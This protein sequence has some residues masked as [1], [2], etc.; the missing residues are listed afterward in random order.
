MSDYGPCN[1]WCDS[2]AA[3]QHAS[4][5]SGKDTRLHRL[6]AWNNGARC[7]ARES[8]SNNSS[9]FGG[10]TLGSCHSHC[11]PIGQNELRICVEVK[12]AWWDRHQ[13]YIEADAPD[14]FNINPPSDH[15]ILE[16]YEYGRAE[17]TITNNTNCPNL[18]EQ[19][20]FS[21]WQTATP[22]RNPDPA[23]MTP[24]R[25]TLSPLLSH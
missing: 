16:D 7:C 22:S 10:T 19:V 9:N 3:N 20:S 25:W 18:E 21:V 8:L 5:P 6:G 1:C 14:C 4:Q 13:I 2:S 11:E 17:F 15:F 12:K 24:V 23:N